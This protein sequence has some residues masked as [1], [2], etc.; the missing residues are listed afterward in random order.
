MDN[1]LPDFDFE[2]W[3][4]LAKE[5]PEEFDAMCSNS[6]QDIIQNAPQAQKHRLEGLQWKIDQ[7]S[8]MSA[9]PI[10]ACIKISTLMWEH[11]IEEGGLQDHISTLTEPGDKMTNIPTE[12]AEIV[13]FPD[14]HKKE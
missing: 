3:A 6:I 5:S 7:I 9:T 8:E 12:N 13:Q 4:K 11:V 14:P 1:K 2:L 10:S